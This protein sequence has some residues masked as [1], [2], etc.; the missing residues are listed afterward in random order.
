VH[1]ERKDTVAHKAIRDRKDGQE[2][3]ALKVIVDQQD[4]RA[5][6]ALLLVQVPKE[7]RV[8]RV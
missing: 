6:Q 4:A 5:W 1:K 7:F 3:L 2:I 8:H